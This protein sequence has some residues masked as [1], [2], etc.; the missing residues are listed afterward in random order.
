MS[1]TSSTSQIVDF[2][3][4]LMWTRPRSLEER[5]TSLSCGFPIASPKAS[6]PFVRHH[7]NP[8]DAVKVRNLL[9]L[10]FD[11]VGKVVSA[12][13]WLSGKL[14]FCKREASLI[15][16]EMMDVPPRHGNSSHEVGS[17]KHGFQNQHPHPEVKNLSPPTSWILNDKRRSCWTTV[18]G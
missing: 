17:Q 4:N 5:N 7:L 9:F 16:G 18:E 12:S 1:P 2:W 11:F 6:K 10:L 8:V 13:V 3:R 15:N 14:P